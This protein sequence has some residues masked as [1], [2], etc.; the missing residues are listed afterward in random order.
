[1]IRDCN[2]ERSITFLDPVLES[3]DNLALF[4]HLITTAKLNLSLIPSAVGNMMAS[5]TY[6]T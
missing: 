1:M 3:R 2:G 6:S 5:S 4:L